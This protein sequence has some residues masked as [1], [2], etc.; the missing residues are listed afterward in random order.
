MPS[1]LTPPNQNS[2]ITDALQLGAVW[3]TYTWRKG[4]TQDPADNHLWLTIGSADTLLVPEDDALIEID[5]DT[6]HVKFWGTTELLEG[7]S[8]GENTL[9]G[10][11]IKD[12]T[13]TGDKLIP[14]IVIDGS[15]TKLMTA[16]NINGILFDGTNNVIN[17]TTCATAGNQTN[18]DVSVTNFQLVTGAM[19]TVRFAN[20]NTAPNPT[21]N[22]NGTGRY[23]IRYDRQTI[24]AE[25]IVSTRYYTFVYD[26]TAYN[27]IGDLATDNTDENV[28]IDSND[29]SKTYTLIG[30]DQNGGYNG[31]VQ[32]V[33]NLTF[34]SDNQLLTVQKITSDANGSWVQINHQNSATINNTSVSNLAGLLTAKVPTGVFSVSRTSTAL[35]ATYITNDLVDDDYNGT[36]YQVSLLDTSGNAT[37]PA[38]VTARR[39]AGVADS[40]LNATNDVDGNPIK[41]TYAKTS[42]LAG[43]LPLNGGTLTGELRVPQI[44]VE[45]DVRVSTV[46]WV[47]SQI[48]Q[49]VDQVKEEIIGTAG[50]FGTIADLTQQVTENT[51]NIESLQQLSGNF[52]RFDQSQS[53]SGNQQQQ[54][55]TNIGAFSSAGGTITGNLSI[56]GLLTTTNSLAINNN[57]ITTGQSPTLPTHTAFNVNTSTGNDTIGS[58]DVT[59]DVDNSVT[60]SLNAKANT[61]S[62]TTR[63]ISI[64]SRADG[65][66]ATSAPHPIGGS[67]DSSIATTQWVNDAIDS[68]V[69]TANQVLAEKTYQNVLAASTLTTVEQGMIYF[70][71]IIPDNALDSWQAKYIIDV[72]CPY[73]S[74]NGIAIVELVGIGQTIDYKYTVAHKSADTI[75]FDGINYRAATTSALAGGNGHFIGLSLYHST[76]PDIVGYERTINVKLVQADNCRVELLDSVGGAADVGIT[77][78]THVANQLVDTQSTGFYYT[79]TTNYGDRLSTWDRLPVAGSDGLLS[80]TLAGLD[81]SQQLVPLFK[82]GAINNVPIDPYS[83]V[84]YTGPD[85]AGFET[86]NVTGTL[87][88]VHRFSLSSIGIATSLVAGSRL[89]I[90]GTIDKST[91]LFTGQSV[92]TAFD[93]DPNPNVCFLS[94]GYVGNNGSGYL[95]NTHILYSVNNGEYVP[96]WPVPVVTTPDFSSNDTTIAT[97]E[98]V[99]RVANQVST[100]INPQVYTDNDDET[101]IYVNAPADVYTRGQT[102]TNASNSITQ[103]IVFRDSTPLSNSNQS[104]TTIASVDTFATGNQ[105]SISM[106]VIQPDAQQEDPFIALEIG[107]NKSGSTWTPYATITESPVKT[108]N[109]NAIATTKYVQENMADINTFLQVIDC[110][111]IP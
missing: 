57:S 13:I 23:P 91:W 81:N 3:P 75:S 66:V 12:G 58:V 17:Y 29:R 40:A 54:A 89:W 86:G 8:F 102:P 48:K 10:S 110:G 31:H 109:S 27:V 33:G 19:I 82:D 105:T 92:V 14:G 70:T 34:D 28:T 5:P 77:S 53:L 32:L 106:S 56:A 72:T 94:L 96:L 107:Y 41:S 22:V 15:I 63:S 73:D 42:A 45:T 108:D 50:D 68:A 97:T 21:L 2:P 88:T 111:E 60:T 1:N 6:K 7:V 25:K 99:Q 100:L 65:T 37:F 20:D 85:L 18:K 30:T 61:T 80:N 103:S 49:S 74:Y 43:Y 62:G 26:G 83:I 79:S 78:S 24:A 64:T 46:G 39:F 59:V 9:E 36:S 95:D 90:K 71:K 104:E 101:A 76:N 16:R 47:E 51:T 67:D 55:R 69:N 87:Y 44:D 35:L 93:N 98:F 11:S 52:V 4:G 84:Y 38:T